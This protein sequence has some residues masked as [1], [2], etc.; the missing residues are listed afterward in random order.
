MWLS[1]LRSSTAEAGSPR[2]AAAPKAELSRIFI[3]TFSLQNRSSQLPRRRPDPHG[4]LPYPRRSYREFFIFTFSLQNRSSQVSTAEAGSPRRAVVPNVGALVVIFFM[5]AMCLGARYSDIFVFVMCLGARRWLTFFIFAMVAPPC[6]W[7][8]AADIFHI[9]HVSG[10]SFFIF[11]MCMGVR[12]IHFSYM[13][14][15]WA[16]CSRFRHVFGR[17]PLTFLMRLNVCC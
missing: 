10:R 7:A 2:R 12:R 16:F 5:I 15:V 13:S 17:S 11:A 9:R 6:V 4:R 1:Y 8:L 3:F 14:S